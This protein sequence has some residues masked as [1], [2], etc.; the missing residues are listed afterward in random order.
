VDFSDGK[1]TIVKEG[2][3]AKLVERVKQIS[4]NGELARRRGQKVHFVTERAVF[5][6]R[7]QGPVLIEIAPGIDLKRDVLG[8]MRFVPIIAEDL[9][10][11][12]PSI[13]SPTSCGLKS[14]IYS[15]R[16]SGGKATHATQR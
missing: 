12:D 10:I 3:E 6:F 1:L 14:K 13:Y 7:P 2:S 4:F 16:A 8:Q 11:T 9:K 5:E 15:N